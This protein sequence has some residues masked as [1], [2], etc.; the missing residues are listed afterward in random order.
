MTSESGQ[1]VKPAQ[2]YQLW[3]E[4]KEAFF[5]RVDE[6]GGWPLGMKYVSFYHSGPV[7][8]PP[9]RECQF[10]NEYRRDGWWTTIFE[11]DDYFRWKLSGA[12]IKAIQNEGWELAVRKL[13]GWGGGMPK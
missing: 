13:G 1:E 3:G 6:Y 10:S 11:A 9:G 7:S 8:T 5:A 12:A 4:K 2:L